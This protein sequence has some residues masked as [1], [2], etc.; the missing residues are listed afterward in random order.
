MI[1]I[2]YDDG[3]YLQ[4]NLS[5]SAGNVDAFLDIAE[6]MIPSSYINLLSQ[7]S[8]KV[9]N[10]SDIPVFSFVFIIL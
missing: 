5:G 2:S 6:L 9:V 1:E 3:E 10:N 7:G 4:C 8:V